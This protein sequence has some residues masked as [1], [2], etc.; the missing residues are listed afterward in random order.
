MS[1]S[2]SAIP[3]Y[4]GPGCHYCGRLPNRFTSIKDGMCKYCRRTHSPSAVT[5]AA[6]V[7]DRIVELE[8]EIKRLKSRPNTCKECR[9]ANQNACD[10][11]ISNGGPCEGSSY[12]TK[13][14]C[15]DDKE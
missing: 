4:N 7:H 6:M 5:N 10:R 1:D 11:H 12:N 9:I 3:G 2:H 15:D 13:L 8:A 14:S